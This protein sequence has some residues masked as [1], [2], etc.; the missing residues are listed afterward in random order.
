MIR[1]YPKTFHFSWSEN[2]KN[3]DRMLPNDNIFV[4]KEVVVTC[5]LD[6]ECS[7]LSQKH[8]H[9]RSLDGLD[10][11]SRHWLKSFHGQLRHNIPKDWE[12]FGEN[13]YACHSIFYPK[14][15][16]FF[17]VFGIVNDKGFF[18]SWDE[19][20]EFCD[21]LGIETVPLLWR[22]IWDIDK[23]KKCYP[24]HNYFSAE[25]EGYVVRTAD[26]FDYND[27]EN[28]VGK[29]VRSDHIKTNKHW[30]KNWFPNR[31]KDETKPG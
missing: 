28:N 20:K 30:L 7:G 24:T 1:K 9:A 13:L 16:T 29:F 3:D 15:T 11:P 19:M 31:L 18:L 5:K 12:I 17:Y 8:C 21:I 25:Q 14:L 22:G 4:G 23:V 26:S 2:L 27:F 10:H 6:G